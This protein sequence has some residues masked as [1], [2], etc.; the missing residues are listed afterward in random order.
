VHDNY[1][2][3]FNPSTTIRYELSEKSN[4]TL[5]VVNVYGQTVRTI[6]QSQR[7]PG[8]HSVSWDGRSDTGAVVASGVYFYTIKAGASSQT[9]SM[10]LL[11]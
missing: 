3:P 4:V 2:N 11:K 10:T 5:N 9:R 7:P 1:P 6:D 8:V